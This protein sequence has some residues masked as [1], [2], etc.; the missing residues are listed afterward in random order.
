MRGF[1]GVAPQGRPTV[2]AAAARG[3][4]PSAGTEA[5][6]IVATVLWAPLDAAALTPVPP[7]GTARA[8]DRAA[9]MPVSTL[10]RW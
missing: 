2:E 10:L 8:R 5:R 3:L 9:R 4:S 6:G 1:A 7:W